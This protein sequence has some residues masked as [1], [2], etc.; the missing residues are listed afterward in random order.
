M[1]P[2]RC[3]DIDYSH[4]LIAA[5]EA[6]SCTEA[7]R[8]HPG[9]DAPAHDA[10]TRML[11]R[12]PP[13]PAA[14]WADAQRLV[15]RERGVLVVDD[16]TLDKPHGRHI[17]LVTR[18][19]SG[20]HKRV[21]WG[22][23]LTTVLWTDG[24]A[25]VPVDVRVYA[26]ATDGLTKNAHLRA[27]LTT[28]AARGFQP[29]YVLFDSWYSGLENLKHLRRLGWRR[30]C[31]IKHNR[32]VNPDGAGN[33][34]VSTLTLPERGR[35]VHLKGYGLVRVFRTVAPDG[36]AEYWASDDRELTEPQRAERTGQAWGIETYHRAIKQCCGI[37]CC[38]VRS[39]A[40]QLQHLLCAVR[41]FLRLEAHRL[42]TG[43]TWYEAKRA[44]IRDAVRHYLAHPLYQLPSLGTA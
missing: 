4:F 32:L 37:A 6:F 29:A 38:Q 8:T 35:E 16:T 15:A 27:M 42:R 22:I 33:V 20:T 14:V 26:K 21:V 41:A 40:G 31:R 24:Q 25:V 19:W 5:T 23:N 12:Q 11:T 7:A 28:A 39:A 9:P 43:T 34:A 3:T 36:H 30:L 1:N 18:H 2:A 17:A 44:I 13:D 10:I